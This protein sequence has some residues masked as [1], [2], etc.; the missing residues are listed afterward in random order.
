MLGRSSRR[1]GFVIGSIHIRL[2]DN[3]V[4]G[5]AE[6]ILAAREVEA[7]DQDSTFLKQIIRIYFN[8]DLAIQHEV[9][10]ILSNAPHAWRLTSEQFD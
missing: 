8:E 5:D 3:E 4:Y 6:S 7:S 10:K 2:S 9:C 1:R